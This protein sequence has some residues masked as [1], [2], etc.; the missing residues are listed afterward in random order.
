MLPGNSVTPPCS[1][2]PSTI[3]G[4][5]SPWQEQ[6]T[7]SCLSALINGLIGL[8]QSEGPTVNLDF[9]GISEQIAVINLRVAADSP[10]DSSLSGS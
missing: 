3:T 4:A 8:W 10:Q 9:P 1:L 7:P 6:F 5:V 2:P